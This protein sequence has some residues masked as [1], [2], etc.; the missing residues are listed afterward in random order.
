MAP[1]TKAAVGLEV[2]K[3][4]CA[5]CIFRPHCADMLPRLLKAIADPRMPGH[6]KGHRVCHHSRTAVCAGFWAKHKNDF[7]LGQ[8]AQRLQL[9]KFVEHDTLGKGAGRGRHDYRRGKT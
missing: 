7:D 5:T 3:R 8:L 4:M 6:F 2:Q 1:R 9:V